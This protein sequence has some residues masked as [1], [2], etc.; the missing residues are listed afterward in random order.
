MH[1]DLSTSRWPAPVVLLSVALM[2]ILG[3]CAQGG[4]GGGEQLGDGRPPNTPPI[5]LPSYPGESLPSTSE[6]LI[7]KHAEVTHFEPELDNVPASI[8]A[9]YPGVYVRYRPHPLRR[10]IVDGGL[11]VDPVAL[12]LKVC[13]DPGCLGGYLEPSVN[14]PPLA[15]LP[16]LQWVRYWKRLVNVVVPHPTTY[17][18]SHTYTEG[19]SE[20][21]GES[22]SVSL[23]LS[24]SGWGLGLSAELTSTFSHS[25]TISSESS[26]T[27]TFTCPSEA[28]STIQFTVWQLVEGFQFCN[29]DGTPFTDPE[30]DFYSSV[31]IASETD[32]LYMSVARF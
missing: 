1:S 15:E 8:A 2:L 22:F 28:G 30:Y 20:M 5:P 27:K 17:Q 11:I 7:F 19:T 21:T 32:E 12:P 4:A 18:Q 14:G 29:D 3:G 31:T 26:V 16:G 25:V 9:A 23:G 24:A 10:L 6:T 13:S